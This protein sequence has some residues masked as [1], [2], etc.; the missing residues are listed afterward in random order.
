MPKSSLNSASK[1]SQRLENCRTRQR[2]SWLNSSRADANSS[3]IA[4]RS[5]I[6]KIDDDI[7]QQVRNS[8]IWLAEEK[9]LTSVSGVSTTTART[10]LSQLP[11][12][13]RLSSR[14]IAALVG[15]ALYPRESGGWRGKRF[16]WGGRAHVRT[17]LYM[18]ALS[19]SQHNPVLSEFYRRLTDK[20]K[21]PR[22]HYRPRQSDFSGQPALLIT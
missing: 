21:P 22:G 16:V 2:C 11:E 8:P 12:L 1:F 14:Q 5:K 4:W 3:E 7:D 6:A 13:R 20:G 10:L 17:T 19:D 18:P 9:L 15:L